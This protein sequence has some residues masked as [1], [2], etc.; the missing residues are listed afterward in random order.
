MNP[1]R[2]ID[3]SEPLLV[4]I[5]GGADSVALLHYLVMHNYYCIAT[6]CNFHLRG[7]ESDRDQEFVQAFCDH[8]SVPLHIAHFD[9]KKYA[10]ENNMSI[11]M[12]AREQRYQYFDK[13]SDDLNIKYIAVAHHADDQ[14]ETFLLNLI[15]G[16]GIRGLSG[17]KPINGKIIRPLLKY[18][19]QDIEL[20]CR[21]HKLKFVTDSTNLSDAYVRNRIRHKVV[22][23]LKSINLSF[24]KTMRHNMQHLSDIAE[25]FAGLVEAFKGKAVVELEGQVLIS[26]EHLQELQNPEP[27]IYEIVSP[28][29]FS[30]DSIHKMANCVDLHHWGRIFFTEKYRAI[31]DRFNLIIIPRDTDQESNEHLI[32]ADQAE[33]FSP[34]HLTFRMFDKTEDFQMSK[35]TDKI[36][37]DAEKIYFPLKLRHWENGDAFRPLGMKGYKKVSDFFVDNKFSQLEKEQTWLLLSGEEIIWIVGKRIDDRVKITEKTK[38]ILELTV[39]NL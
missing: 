1:L 38:Q 12:A 27:Y 24:L 4:A 6:H 35:T 18:S 36:H 34:I 31:V 28:Y 32:E 15:R 39:L 14:S 20:Y 2:T 33:I 5:S 26:M 10:A 23:E 29:G 16:T 25:I 17:M 30:A 22:P 11:E 8:L 9:T 19:R 13:L 37:I 3:K 21:A 7:D